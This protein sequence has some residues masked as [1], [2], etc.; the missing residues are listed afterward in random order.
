M[1][2]AAFKIS[3]RNHKETPVRVDV[4]EP[5]PADWTILSSTFGHEK[6][7]AF[8]AIFPLEVP[9]DGETVLEYRVRVQY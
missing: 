9:V 2:E 4:V 3:V 8:T 1:F 5:M 6:K 7:D